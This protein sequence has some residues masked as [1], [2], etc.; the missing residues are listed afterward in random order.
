MKCNMSKISI[1]V[2]CEVIVAQL[3]EDAE[4]CAWT[5]RNA[6]ERLQEAEADYLWEDLKDSDPVTIVCASSNTHS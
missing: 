4:G 2:P 5:I 6:I 3:Q 1:D